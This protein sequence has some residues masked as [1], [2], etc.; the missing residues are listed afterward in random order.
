M[1]SKKPYKIAI[2]APVPFYYHVPLYRKLAGAPEIDLTVYYCSDETLYGTDIEKT[3]NTKGSFAT[4]EDLLRGYRYKFLKNYSPLSSYL[5]WPFGLINFSIW[6]E[7]KQ[8]NYDAAVLQSWTNLTWWLAFFACLR[9]RTPILFMTDSNIASESS[10]SKI[11]IYIKKTI[12]GNFLFKEAGG[13]LTSG[14]ANEEFYKYYGVPDSKMTRIPFSWGYDKL[15]NKAE[16]LK[17][18]RQEIRSSF[19]IE[20]NDFVILYVGRLSKEKMPLI[21]LDA[22]KNINN[23]NK[24][25][26]IVGDGPLHQQFEERIKELD[27]KRVYLF[28]FQPHEKIPD[29]YVAS[30]VLVLPSMHETWGIVVNEAMCFGLPVIVSDKVGAAVDLVRDG[31]N[32]FIF[33]AKDAEKLYACIEK[34]INL[35]S[36]ER[37][38]FGRRS[39][40]IIHR[41]VKNIDPAEQIMKALEIT[42]KQS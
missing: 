6:K 27:I 42:K 18:R 2:I 30:D 39:F 33:P 8:G 26:F 17:I 35:T 41:W 34:L 40:E 23:K 12:L 37:E 21:I 38:V 32:G 15:L 16:Q 20:K 13:F 3:Y 24:K 29:F 31:Y 28:G 25:L 10:K 19:G 36:A 1:E 4:K 9:F 5:R 22:Y 7:I 14:T 11:K